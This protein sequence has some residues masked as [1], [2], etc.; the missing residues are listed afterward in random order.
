MAKQ[1]LSSSVGE[2][3]SGGE[4]GSAASASR[5]AR[6]TVSPTRSL[7]GVTGKFDGEFMVADGGKR[8]PVPANYAS[9]SQ[10]VFGDTLK[11]IEQPDGRRIFKQIERVKRSRVSGVLARKD[12]RWCVVTADGSYKV[13][14]AA[15]AYYGGQEGDEAQ[16]LLPQADRHAPFAALESIP[17]RKE[18][19][20]GKKEAEK[21]AEVKE[22]KKLVAAEKPV[23]KRA[24]EGKAQEE[25]KPAARKPVKKAA[26]KRPAE[27]K[28]RPAG[29][30]IKKEVRKKEAEKEKKTAAKREAQ[31]KDAIA[32]KSR[33]GDEGDLR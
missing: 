12:G 32:E 18:E 2:P 17:A 24:D 9:K 28:E 15:V 8:Y 1:L 29:K 16:A 14:A 23:E 22:E 31:A 20:K 27:K 25:G 33:A 10:M 30:E 5:E 7:P 3:S 21:P 4:S 6:R 19:R 13:L 11:M 26:E